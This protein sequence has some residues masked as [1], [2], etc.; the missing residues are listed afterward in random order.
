MARR[1]SKPFDPAEAARQ[2]LERDRYTRNTPSEWGVNE[3]AIS[4][5][6]DIH[7]EGATR[8]R[9]RRLQRY[10]VFHL[11]HARGS[12]SDAS[13]EA[14]R[15]LQSD[16]ATQHHVD[17]EG[18]ATTRTDGATSNREF[19]A[20]DAGNRVR[21]VLA[22]ID[23]HDQLLLTALIIPQIVHGERVNWKAVVK[24]WRGHDDRALQVK[25]VKV[26]TEALTTA[27]QTIDYGQRRA[28]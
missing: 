13:L 19:R 28:A 20:I 2:A 5:Q 15:R 14:I 22:R 26:A 10:D 21:D 16:I 11:L 23:P 18:A 27:Y 17:G 8:T 12:L 3:D 24:T 6:D 4:T 9:V 7:S 1:K 25:A